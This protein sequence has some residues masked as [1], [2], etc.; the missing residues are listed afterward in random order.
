MTKI[1]HVNA[2][3]RGESSQSR[4]IADTFLTSLR[5][6]E[7]DLEI[8]TWNLFDG[9]LPEFGTVAAEAKMAVFAGQ[10]QTPEQQAAWESA[11]EVFDRFAAADAYVFNVPMWNA[12]VPY[13]LKQWIDIIT[14]P[15]WAF[16]F[17]PAAGYNGLVAGKR[18]FVVYTSGVYAPG[19]SLEFGADFTSTFFADWLRFVG[20][21]DVEELRFAPTV[22]TATPDE[23]FANHKELAQKAAANF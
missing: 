17:D 16:G 8:D 2:S 1:L 20:I 15:G 18:A 13:V 12:G 6:R 4:A 19:V 3:A 11:R 14:Q 21:T 5:E 9:S 22:M 7:S 23:D 10:E